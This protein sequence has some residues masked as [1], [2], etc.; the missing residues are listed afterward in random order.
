MVCSSC[1][2]DLDGPRFFN[3]DRPL[4]IG[5]VVAIVGVFLWAAISS[6][7]PPSKRDTTGGAEITAAVSVCEAAGRAVG[8]RILVSG[9]FR[10]TDDG[11]PPTSITLESDGLCSARGGGLVFATVNS[12]AEM[13][14]INKA[15]PRSDRT[16]TPGTTLS[17]EGEVVKVDEGRFVHLARAIVR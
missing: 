13:L 14:K 7:R 1:E 15:V 17:V 5:A 12:R 3:I 9:E 16:R 10:G 8:E 6:Y 4:I 11:T 2:R